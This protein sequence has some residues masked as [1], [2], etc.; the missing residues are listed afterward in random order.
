MNGNNG[1]E[2]Y[3]GLNLQ[4]N[5]FNQMTT[6]GNMSLFEVQASI[7]DGGSGSETVPW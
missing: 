3:E 2:S 6:P 5:V 4:F 7:P 1:R